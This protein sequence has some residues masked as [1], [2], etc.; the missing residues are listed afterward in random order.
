M[1]RKR[2]EK[3]AS[4][5]RLIPGIYN[6]CDRWCE[7]CAFTSRCMN[8]TVCEEVFDDPESH[9]VKS[10]AFWDGLS[11]ILKMTLEMV[12]ER[13]DELGIDLKAADCDKTAMQTRQTREIASKHPCSQTAMAYAESVDNWFETNQT[14]IEET[15]GELESLVRAEIPGTYPDNDVIAI[16]DCIQ[17]IRWYQHQIYVKLCRAATGKSREELQDVQG[18]AHDANG[19]A[20][21]ALIAIERSMA[22]WAKLLSHLSD[23]ERS[24]LH[25]LGNLQRLETRVETAF[26]AARTFLRPGFDDQ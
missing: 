18:A 11:D 14:R 21:V 6:Y 17:V 15:A 13:A 24:I 16:N 19:S 10:K 22:A 5:P 12:R 4:D 23:Q 2:I 7:R 9:D 1:D 26:P 25:L 3:L 20:K 8:Y